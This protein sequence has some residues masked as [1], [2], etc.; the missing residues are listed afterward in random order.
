[1]S[2]A[3]PT[4]LSGAQTGVDRGAA[5]AALDNRATFWGW[6]P[7]GRKA[8]DGVIPAHFPMVET[9][10]D[11]YWERTEANVRDSSATLIIAPREVLDGGTKRTAEIADRY[12]RPCLPIVPDPCGCH[13]IPM[14]LWW[15]ER[16]KVESLNVAGPRASK[17]AAG[18]DAAYHMVGELIVAIRKRLDDEIPF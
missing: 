17:W 8:E 4:F 14:L 13:A 3:E 2:L 10:S 12:G 7:L 15:L 16:Y 9:A 6:C 5:Q 18:Y 11:S 1:M